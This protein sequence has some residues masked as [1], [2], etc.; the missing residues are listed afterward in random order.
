MQTANR[1][2]RDDLP[3]RVLSVMLTLIAC[4]LMIVSAYF[5]RP[6]VEGLF[7]TE[8]TLSLVAGGLALGGALLLAKGDRKLV[9]LAPSMPDLTP[10]QSRWWM[11]VLGAL[12]LA[13][14]AEISGRALKIPVLL[15]VNIH[16]QFALL[17][18][19]ILLVGW[20]SAGELRLRFSITDRRNALLLGGIIL[21][22]LVVR[23]WGLDT[24]ARFMQDETIF[25]DAVRFFWKGNNP[26][27]LNGGGAV[28]ITLVYPYW[29][30]I[31]VALF[32]RNLIG[33]R[34]ASALLGVCAIP[35]AYELTRVLLDKRAGLL[36]ALFVA[37][38]PPH[39]HFSR[40]SWGHMGDALFGL[41][42]LMFIARAIRWNW[43][44]D[45]AFAGVCLGLTQYFY[46]V[47]RLIYPPLIL[48]WFVLLII[49]WGMKRYRRGFLI[50]VVAAVLVATP[51]YYFIAVRHLPA[52]PRT[53]SS[54]T[55]M[56]Y[57]KQFLDG[58][59]SNGDPDALIQRVTTPFLIYIQHADDSS[60]YYGGFEG[61]VSP[62]L[63]P[64]FLLGVVWVLWHIRSPIGILLT[65]PLF[66]S[67]ANIFAADPGFSPRYVVFAPLIP[68]VMAVGLYGVL[69][70]LS[71]SRRWLMTGLAA[72][73]ALWQIYFY[74]GVHLPYYNVQRRRWIPE[75]D[76][77]DAV[78]RTPDLPANT[79]V[80]LIDP[81]PK[82]DYGRAD[83][84]YLFL[85]DHPDN[86]QAPTR[87]EFDPA[88]LPHDR[89]YA[90]FIAPGDVELLHKIQSAFGEV[91][92]P[93][94]T[95]E[96]VPAWDEYILIL[97]P[98]DE[99]NPR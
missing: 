18:I 10:S 59:L 16:L 67:L 99:Q 51:V 95:T 73:V 49:D 72:G 32:G 65:A 24:I 36:A 87:A 83:R 48:F 17:V 8:G 54:A 25:T 37:T 2:F 35:V 27:L 9:T 66:G 69:N 33:L 34:L 31:M 7:L 29:N 96:T 6:G 81:M 43:R 71:I 68:T 5:F 15:N 74:F 3:R 23:V 79:E 64:L 92:A 50:V 98:A 4:G 28:T 63:V 19:G 21:I 89:S 46:E 78:L 80:F 82:I 20:G 88:A 77:F 90:F 57:W 58:N 44:A 60:E 56:D 14:V 45:W 91:S 53:N 41:M 85:E 62:L 94:Y 40:I 22:G 13:L 93:L 39:I 61:L 52:T 26:G 97:W 76:V 30:A 11:V 70:L 42:A 75:R 38:F 1:A 55:S 86:I 12:L 84:L 47:G